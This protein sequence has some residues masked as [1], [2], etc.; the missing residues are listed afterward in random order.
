MG[1]LI[2]N[3]TFKGTIVDTAP[4]AVAPT[5]TPTDPQLFDT[6]VTFTVTNPEA[7]PATVFF[8]LEDP[9]PRTNFVVVG[10]NSTSDELE[11]GGNLDEQTTHTIN[12]AV[13]TTGKITSITSQAS[14]TTA[15]KILLPNWET[16]ITLLSNPTNTDF[17]T[18]GTLRVT[19]SPDG[20]YFAWNH[21][22][23][24]SQGYIPIRVPYRNIFKRTGD[25]FSMLSLANHGTHPT[26]AAQDLIFSPDGVHLVLGLSSSPFIAIYKQ[27]GDTFTKLADPA[28]F[29][30]TTVRGLDFS[31]DGNYLAMNL[32]AEPF[33]N[34]YKRD[35]DTFT[36]IADPVGGLP[37][38]TLFGEGVAFSTDTVYLAVGQRVTTPET[39]VLHMYKRDG[40]TF[41]KLAD[42]VG[43]PNINIREIK[44]IPNSPY[45]LVGENELSMYKRN[46]DTLTKLANTHVSPSGG[47]NA[48]AVSTDGNYVVAGGS[49]NP[50]LIM[51]YKRDGDNLN[52]FLSNPTSI[53]HDGC[54]ALA[55]S[56]NNSPILKA[57]LAAYLVQLT[58]QNTSADRLNLYK[59]TLS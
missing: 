13:Q 40:D 3:K 28:I 54:K 22:S 42:P 30:S 1:K 44:S 36:K 33:I 35:G 7:N 46:G 4:R 19:F 25:S 51:M 2:Y 29:P 52:L 27:N 41:T 43:V 18:D 15:E 5:I 32:S 37:T 55:F 10:A 31:S 24:S 21:S 49:N 59:T 53:L 11:L 48:I 50:N 16:S 23:S 20:N 58:G 12:A 38:A 26:S 57:E 9:R 34:I 8:G 6:K 56:P 14:A 17:Q 45:L 47:A 39:P